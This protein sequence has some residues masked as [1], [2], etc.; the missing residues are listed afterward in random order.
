M[1]TSSSVGST[2]IVTDVVK[3]GFG[4]AFCGGYVSVICVGLLDEG[5]SLSGVLFFCF[6]LSTP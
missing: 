5:I 6:V 4:P 3:A 1:T 2:I